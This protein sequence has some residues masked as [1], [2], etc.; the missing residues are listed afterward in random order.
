MEAASSLQGVKLC[1]VGQQKPAM[2]MQEESEIRSDSSFKK[3]PLS[4]CEKFGC[5]AGNPA[6]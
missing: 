5:L 3:S 1:Q 2:I 4:F 6:L